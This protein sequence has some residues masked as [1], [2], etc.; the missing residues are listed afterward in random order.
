MC[1][2]TFDNSNWFDKFNFYDH[3]H[4]VVVFKK[5]V[6]LDSKQSGLEPDLGCGLLRRQ[7]FQEESSSSPVLGQ[8]FSFGGRKKNY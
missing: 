7:R 8:D 3:W 6:Q 5:E 4:S 1:Y 2:I